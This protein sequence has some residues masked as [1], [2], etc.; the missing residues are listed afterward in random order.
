MNGLSLSGNGQE[1]GASNNIDTAST[2]TAADV[3]YDI[4]AAP[5]APPS[6]TLAAT[7]NIPA[8][9]FNSNSPPPDYS[10]LYAPVPTVTSTSVSAARS[11]ESPPSSAA[12]GA[13]P[14]FPPRPAACVTTPAQMQQMYQQSPPPAFTHPPANNTDPRVKDSIELC[15]FAI[16]ALGVRIIL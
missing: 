13:A 2:I 10:G 12:A 1:G 4:P 14:Y 15:Q 16:A 7:G 8:A 5:V 11:T 6:A 9:P 3:P